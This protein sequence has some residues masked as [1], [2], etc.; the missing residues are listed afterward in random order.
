MASTPITKKMREEATC[1]ICLQLIT[2]PVSISCGHSYC[3][4]CIVSFCEMQPWLEMFSCPQCRMPFIMASL[5]PNKQLGNLIEAVKE[6]DQEMSCEEHGEKLHLFC[7]DEGQLI[8]WRCDRGLQHKG[9]TTALVEDAC[10]GY[11]VSGGPEDLGEYP[12]SCC[13]QDLKLFS[14]KPKIR[15]LKYNFHHVI[16]LKSSL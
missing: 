9:H 3:H 2:E 4:L 10:Q 14:L 11:K 6:M 1:S 12:A 7:E 13:P 15:I 16:L 5:R 8:C